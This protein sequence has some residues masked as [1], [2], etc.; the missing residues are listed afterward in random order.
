MPESSDTAAPS[1][2]VVD[3]SGT[4]VFDFD[5]ASISLAAG[6]QRSVLVRAGGNRTLA[7]TSLAIRFN[8]AVVAA[9]A[10]RPILAS[11]GLADGRVESG[12]VIVEIPS[13]LS[14]AGTQAVAEI[15]LQGIAAGNSTLSFDKVP[16]GAG[17]IPA[18][19]EVR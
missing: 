5:P 17:S 7:N 10:V 19:V 8:P 12:R 14:L 11:G 13:T 3:T 6:Q 1:A 9:V 18:V 4:V 15:V 2:A 16:D